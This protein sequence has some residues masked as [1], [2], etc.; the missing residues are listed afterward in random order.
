MP[1]SFAYGDSGFAITLFGLNGLLTPEDCSLVSLTC[2]DNSGKRLHWQQSYGNSKYGG[3]L[4]MSIS[5][6]DARSPVVLNG[7][8]RYRDRKF[9]FNATL[10][11][12]IE[13][14]TSIPY[15]EMTQHKISGSSD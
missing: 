11:R 9:D 4:W 10:R 12:G 15:W 7:V 8:L 5:M 14:D 6:R 3:T 1:S 2:T 13:L